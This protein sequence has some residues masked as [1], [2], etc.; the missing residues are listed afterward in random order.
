MDTNA[1]TTKD[2]NAGITKD[3][4]TNAGAAKDEDTNEEDTKATNAM[5]ESRC[6][7]ELLHLCLKAWFEL[8]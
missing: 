2:T 4:G 6:L 8:K 1:G 5:P 7:L 3:E